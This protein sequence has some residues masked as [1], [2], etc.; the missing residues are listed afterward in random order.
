MKVSTDMNTKTEKIWKE[1]YAKLKWF[2]T[3]HV[4]TL[5]IPDF[6]EE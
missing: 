5:I 6:L 2:I 3:K 1:F 4:R